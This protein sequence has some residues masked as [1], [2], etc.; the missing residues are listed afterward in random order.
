MPYIRL[1]IARLV[2]LALGNPVFSCVVSMACSE[3]RISSER[4]FV[5]CSKVSGVDATLCCARH[6]TRC[7]VSADLRARPSDSSCDGRRRRLCTAGEVTCSAVEFLYC[8]LAVLLRYCPL[9]AV[10]PSFGTS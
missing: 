6:L 8:S 5:L 4:L 2:R 1:G 7:I 9:F 3:R 10:T